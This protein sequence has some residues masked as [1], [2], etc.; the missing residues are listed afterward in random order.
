[1]L[2]MLHSNPSAHLTSEALFFSFLIERGGNVEKNP[3][4]IFLKKKKVTGGAEP[5]STAELSCG[6]GCQ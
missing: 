3:Y 2:G 6:V 1:M 5:S 4:K